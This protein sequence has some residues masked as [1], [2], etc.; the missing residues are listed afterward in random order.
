[1]KIVF[2]DIENRHSLII[3]VWKSITFG[4]KK[5]QIVRV[6]ANLTIGRDRKVNIIL[7]VY[8]ENV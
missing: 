7:D 4:I 6:R 3:F 2:K 5:W 8:N 1:M